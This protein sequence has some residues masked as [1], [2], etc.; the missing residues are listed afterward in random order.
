MIGDVMG[1]V[2]SFLGASSGS[3]LCCTSKILST[4]QNILLRMG[5]VDQTHLQFIRQE[6]WPL[7][8][9]LILWNMDFLRHN[10]NLL[11]GLQII[12]FTRNE[13]LNMDVISSSVRTVCFSDD[14]N[15]P[16]PVGVFPMALEE[17]IFG[18][19][20]D[21]P[22]LPGVFPPSVKR[23]VFCDNFSTPFG[24]ILPPNL[25]CLEFQNCECS[26]V[27]DCLP[28]RL[29]YLKLGY[30]YR[31]IDVGKLPETLIHLELGFLYTWPIEVGVLPNNL[32]YLKLGLFNHPIGINVL[33]KNLKSL[34]FGPRFN[35]PIQPG[36][37]PTGLTYLEFGRDFNQSIKLDVFPP[38]LE[39]LQFGYNFNQPL[40]LPSV[41][42][43]M[44]GFMF[45]QDVDFPLSLQWLRIKKLPPGFR[46]YILSDRDSL[47]D[48]SLDNPTLDLYTGRIG[49]LPTRIGISSK[50]KRDK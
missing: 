15:Q 44:F 45:Q 13:V 36:V 32:Q 1:C 42:H 3:D 40:C 31:R 24:N 12:E 10:S 8:R 20:F 43:L 6:R 19:D 46:E 23:I 4:Y 37:L 17:V 47:R 22:L 7:V 9:K 30:S 50:R 49:E 33:P 48:Y 27:I 35:Q 18:E 25:D 11:R 26:F 21:Q 34:I 5:L 2:I 28:P 16:L 41:K 14:F 29:K 38:G 39:S